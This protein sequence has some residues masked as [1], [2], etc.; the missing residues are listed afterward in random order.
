MSIPY[1]S[2]CGTEVPD[3]TTNHHVC[4]PSGVDAK[5]VPTYVK[6]FRDDAAKA[7][8]RAI[9]EGVTVSEALAR[10]AAGT[11]IVAKPVV[12]ADPVVLP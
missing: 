6:T 12:V 10:N 2:A 3:I 8:D 9:V 7:N 5:G 4:V 1:C 11:P